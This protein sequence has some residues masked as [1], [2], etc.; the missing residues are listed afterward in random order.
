MRLLYK[1][2]GWLLQNSR[3]NKFSSTQ[4]NLD[5]TNTS[6]TRFIVIELW[7]YRDS[8]SS[9]RVGMLTPMWKQWWHGGLKSMQQIRTCGTTTEPTERP[10][11]VVRND[12]HNYEKRYCFGGHKQCKTLFNDHMVSLKIIS[13]Y[14]YKD[15]GS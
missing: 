14:I 15:L 2:L 12:W 1:D 6:Y 4:L 7:L 5:I 11:T 8:I 3:G 13:L 9:H 10:T